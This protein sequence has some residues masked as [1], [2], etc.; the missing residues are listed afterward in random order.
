MALL[1]ARIVS[2]HFQYA[3]WSWRRFHRRG[4]QTLPMDIYAHA[5]H[6]PSVTDPENT[7]QDPEDKTLVASSREI[8]ALLKPMC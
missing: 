8:N 3:N 4:V 5:S 2:L 1:C 7:D 6:R